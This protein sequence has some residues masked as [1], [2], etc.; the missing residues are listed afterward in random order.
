MNVFLHS[1]MEKFSACLFLGVKTSICNLNIKLYSKITELFLLHNHW[2]KIIEKRVFLGYVSGYYF[3]RVLFY[4]MFKSQ[5]CSSWACSAEYALLWADPTETHWSPGCWHW[6]KGL[7]LSSQRKRLTV[8]HT[9][10]SVSY[11]S[12]THSLSHR[13]KILNS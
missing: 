10:L 7:L 12:R 3:P 2:R 6:S 11:L 5:T 4:F 1:N 8:K 13:Q 9:Y